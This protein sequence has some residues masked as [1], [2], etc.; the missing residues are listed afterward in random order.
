MRVTLPTL[1]LPGLGHYGFGQGTAPAGE[2]KVKMSF[3]SS[4][5]RVPLLRFIG[6]MPQ[7]PSLDDSL[8]RRFHARNRV[9]TVALVRVG[10]NGAALDT[11][12]YA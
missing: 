6:S 10:A 2:Q 12:D 4:P 9:K 5:D 11:T 8:A 3:A 1:L 7:R